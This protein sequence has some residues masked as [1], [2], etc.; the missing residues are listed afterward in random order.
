[1]ISSGL[2]QQASSWLSALAIFRDIVRA[3]VNTGYRRTVPGKTRFH[4]GVNVFKIFE[5]NFSKRDAS[6]IRN[7]NDLESCSVQI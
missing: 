3:E 2:H 4:P 5:S 6:L 1:M 7:D